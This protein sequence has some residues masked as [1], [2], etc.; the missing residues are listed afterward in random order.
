MM[1]T[2]VTRVRRTIINV[3]DT[4]KYATYWDGKET[5]KRLVREF[6]PEANADVDHYR[7]GC[8]DDERDGLTITHDGTDTLLTDEKISEFLALTNQTV[9]AKEEETAAKQ[10]KF[11]EDFEF[12]DLSAVKTEDRYQACILKALGE[13]Q[14][15]ARERLDNLEEEGDAYYA[16]FDFPDYYRVLD[17]AMAGEGWEKILEA[18]RDN[19]T[20]VREQF[21][22]FFRLLEEEGK[23]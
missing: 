14:D 15:S 11:V 16:L 5:M 19:D 12:R 2:E 13:L 23:Y 1:T 18:V 7:G 8:R 6:L 20:A 22:D 21:E 10:R 17:V 9:K 3:F 4:P